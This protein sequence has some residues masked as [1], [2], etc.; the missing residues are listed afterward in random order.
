L[1]C[2]PSTT[3]LDRHCIRLGYGT[4]T[5]PLDRQCIRLGYGTSDD[6]IADYVST[7]N[8]NVPV[9]LQDSQLDLIIPDAMKQLG[10]AT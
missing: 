10:V 9:L 2:P 3:P 6:Y 4:S 5:T 8:D 1:R 7:D